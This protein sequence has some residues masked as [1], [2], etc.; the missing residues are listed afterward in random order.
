MFRLLGG[1]LVTPASGI[2]LAVIAIAAVI[3]FALSSNRAKRRHG[4][5]VSSVAATAVRIVVPWP[6][7]GPPDQIG[8]MFAQRLTEAWKQQVIVDNRPGANSIIGSDL[9]AKSAPDGYTWLL[10]TGSHTHN[11]A[12][13]SKPGPRSPKPTSPPWTA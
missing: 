5:E 3:W 11:A 1:A 13:H 6:A 9:V 10:T 4:L 2:V 8:R 12:F 7:G